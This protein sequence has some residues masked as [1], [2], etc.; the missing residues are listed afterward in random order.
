MRAARLRRQG[1]ADM[2]G[3]AGL[4]EEHGSA[5]FPHYL[6]PARELR[7]DGRAHVADERRFDMT[8][9]VDVLAELFALH[10]HVQFPAA[11]AGHWAPPTELAGRAAVEAPPFGTTRRHARGPVTREA[12]GNKQLAKVL[13]TLRA[14]ALRLLSDV[15]FSDARAE[16]VRQ[17][18]EAF[19]QNLFGAIVI[20]KT[21]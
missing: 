9:I 6:A 7:G 19:L 20:E 4:V 17:V 11:N 3:Y 14:D 1:N 21:T 13:A 12:M 16:P 5:L 8:E 10:Q 2:A 18:T 15:S